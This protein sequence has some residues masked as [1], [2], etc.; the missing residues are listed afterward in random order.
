MVDA[1]HSPA[2]VGFDRRT[3]IARFGRELPRSPGDTF[4]LRADQLVPARARWRSHQRTASTTT[5]TTKACRADLIV[6]P[7]PVFR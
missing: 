6:S 5:P 4:R 2:D 1:H 7:L 3:W